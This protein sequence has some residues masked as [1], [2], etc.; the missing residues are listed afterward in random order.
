MEIILTIF[1]VVLLL[2]AGVCIPVLLQI[3]KTAKNMAETLQV[4]NQNLPAIMRNLEEIT[5]N[6]NRTTT[7]VQRQV[8]DFSVVV[9]K[10][11]G[12]L[13]LVAGMEEILRRNVRLNIVQKTR[14]TLAVVKGVRVFLDHILSKRPVDRSCS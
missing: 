4:L 12:A 10:I 8:E 5:T 7:T 2:F 6:I 11:Q 14:T 13:G 1:C 3:W 9:G